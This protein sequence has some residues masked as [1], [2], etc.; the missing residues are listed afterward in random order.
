MLCTNSISY[1]FVQDSHTIVKL[2]YVRKENTWAHKRDRKRKKSK[3]NIK[4]Q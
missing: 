1:I 4:Q 3:R 2:S